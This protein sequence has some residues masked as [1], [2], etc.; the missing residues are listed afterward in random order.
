MTTNKPN[1][2]TMEARERDDLAC[3]ATGWKCP[4]CVGGKHM[5]WGPTKYNRI[6]QWFIESGAD[7]SAWSLKEPTIPCDHQPNYSTSIADAW[8][9]V[10]KMRGNGYVLHLD[11]GNTE[12]RAFFAVPN[13]E[14]KIMGSY[15]PTA[16]TAICLAALRAI[17]AIS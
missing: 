8:L 4:T 10:E 1:W 2:D 5:K 11:D 17:G 15:Q 9:V 14:S 6:R 7:P 16:P 3:K 12:W 13:D